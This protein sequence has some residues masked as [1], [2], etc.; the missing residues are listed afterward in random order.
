MTAHQIRVLLIEDDPD[1]IL[2]LKESLAELGTGKIKL[3]YTDRLS[4]GL[5]QLSGQTYDVILL[6]L[7]L[8]DSRGLDTLNTTIKRFPKIPVVVLSGLADDAITIEAVRRGAQDYLV[9]GEISGPLVLRVLRY[10]IERK[11]VEAVLR[12]SEARYRTLVETSPNGI[13]MIDLEGK[14]QLCNQHAAR[15]HGYDNP[16]S[17]LGLHIFKL[18]APADRHLASLNMNK[19]LN[20]G[21]VTNA[22]YILLRKD[23]SQFPAEISTSLIRNNAGVATGFLDITRDISE[24]K[25]AIESEKRL[26]MLKEKFISGVSDE[27]RTPLIKLMGYLSTLHNRKENDSDLQNEL[28]SRASRDAN[29]ILDMVNEL[30]D[31]SKLESEHLSLNCDKADLVKLVLE[32]VQSY[33][34]QANVRRISLSAAPMCPSLLADVDPVRMR[35]V[36]NKLVENAI[37]FSDVDGKV[38]VTVKP[39]NGDV[40]INV[41]DEGR[42]I[43]LEESSIIFEKYYQVDHTFNK[44]NHGMGVGLYIAKQIIEA[45]AGTL[46]VNSQLGAGSTFTITIPVK[47]KR[48]TGVLTAPRKVEPTTR[49]IV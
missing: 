20:G 16:E 5:I 37:K 18:I 39:M 42:G 47:K 12:A 6:D 33:Q 24:R 30:A 31:F 38:Y 1:D 35:R 4:R 43:S 10:A 3:N 13:T 2:L 15:L 22:E 46:T 27:L 34:E 28:L 40:I 14:L 17:M 11:Q 48:M 19:T 21:K 32:V 49:S 25:N 7:N 23:G 36:L 29:R 44:D 26:V 9:K 8:P 45:H 41:I